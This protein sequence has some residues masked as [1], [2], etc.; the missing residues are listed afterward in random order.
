MPLTSSFCAYTVK[1][2]YP[3]SPV[4]FHTYC[5]AVH[6]RSSVNIKIDTRMSVA[7]CRWQSS[8]LSSSSSSNAHSEYINSRYTWCGVVHR[9]RHLSIF[10]S[11]SS[12]RLILLLSPIES[13]LQMVGIRFHRGDAPCTYDGGRV[14]G[15]CMY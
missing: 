3:I 11:F 8:S 6:E 4:C 9:R 5:F 10:S 15:V 13:M 12:S 14:F 2:V 1:S 7:H